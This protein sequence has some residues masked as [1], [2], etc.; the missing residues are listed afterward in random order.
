M[1]ANAKKTE[2]TNSNCVYTLCMLYQSISYISIVIVKLDDGQTQ[3][4]YK[5]LYFVLYY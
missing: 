3:D 1:K 4:L 5:R 2:K